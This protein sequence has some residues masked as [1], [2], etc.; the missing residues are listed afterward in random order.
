MQV[1]Y[2]VTGFGVIIWAML[3]LDEALCASDL[4]RK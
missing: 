2:L 1:S 3:L 4:R